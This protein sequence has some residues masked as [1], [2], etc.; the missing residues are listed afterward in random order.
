MV[1]RLPWVRLKVAASLNGA[2]AL[3]DGE[4]QWITGATIKVTTLK[5]LAAGSRV[6][7]EIDLV[8]RY[9]ERMLAEAAIAW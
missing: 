5:H 2:T 8:A 6:N 7:R 3:A 9:V 1:R 4:S